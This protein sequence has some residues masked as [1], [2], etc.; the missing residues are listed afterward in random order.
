MP[1]TAGDTLIELASDAP[2]VWIGTAI[3]FL[4]FGLLAAHG[5]LTTAS[6]LASRIAARRR[7]PP[8][9]RT[10]TIV[11]VRQTTDHRAA[12]A[13][14]RAVLEGLHPQTELVR[15]S[16]FARHAAALARE[17]VGEE[18]CKQWPWR[19]VNLEEATED[20]RASYESIHLGPTTYYHRSTH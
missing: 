3:A 7:T 8:D 11:Q 5:F 14:Q 10:M 13:N 4:V 16:E 12:T 15:D 19:H 2:G 20:L 18:H 6:A 17:H 1:F 9:K